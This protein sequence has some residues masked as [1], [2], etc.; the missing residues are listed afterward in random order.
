MQACHL[1]KVDDRAM[2]VHGLR[3]ALTCPFMRRLDKRLKSK[4]GLVQILNCC[5]RK[6]TGVTTNINNGSVL[7]MGSD[8][9]SVCVHS[10]GTF[11]VA[12]TPV[13]FLL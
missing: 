1:A 5:S 3:S 9:E 6:S 11:I 2:F 12:F 8:S 10:T 4:I 13:L 7:F